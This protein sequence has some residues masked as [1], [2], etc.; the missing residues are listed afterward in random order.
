MDLVKQSTLD[1]V[2]Q[3]TFAHFC[4]CPFEVSIYFLPWLMDDSSN[5]KCVV[6]CDLMVKYELHMAN[7][8]PWSMI[9]SLILY[10]TV[11]KCIFLTTNESGLGVSHSGHVEGIHD[12]DVQ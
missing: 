1:E 6:M 11:F 2:I 4:S 5:H 7:M 9:L 10:N 8:P 12:D 3:N